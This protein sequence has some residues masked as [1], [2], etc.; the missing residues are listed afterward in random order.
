[1]NHKT[2][3]L[4]QSPPSRCR[5]QALVE[6][7]VVASSILAALLLW[8]PMLGKY[9][10]IKHRSIQAARYQVWETAVWRIEGQY[11]DADLRGSVAGKPV[12]SKATLKNETML[13]FYTNSKE[14]S[15]T[16]GA[17]TWDSNDVP[18]LWED[19]S[20]A[21]R[22]SLFSPIVPSNNIS[23]TKNAYGSN[24]G[25]L[26][27]S[28]VVGIMDTFS[29][30]LSTVLNVFGVDA[31]FTVMTRKGQFTS[32]PSIVIN[33]PN[34][35]LLRDSR[36]LETPLALNLQIGSQA[37]LTT[38]NWGAAGKEHMRY[39][40]RGLVA[41]SLFDNPVFNIIKTITSWLFPEFGKLEFGYV[42][43]DAVHPDRLEGGGSHACIQANGECSGIISYQ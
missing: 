43:F 10:D 28:G 5:G 21:D 33:D 8:G 30:G 9:V 20:Y 17:G 26:I 12:K 35:Y 7:V 18:S 16:D 2:H 4:H 34:P 37:G 19:H 1:M 39:Q 24:P 42:D 32:A 38:N 31:G 13:R 3:Y 15:S 29:T 41:T 25:G 6:T 23:D 11:E 22:P 40:T 36:S 27:T 14:L